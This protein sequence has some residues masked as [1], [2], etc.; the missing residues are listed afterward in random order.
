MNRLVGP[1]SMNEEQ[2]SFT[3]KTG[4]TTNVDYKVTQTKTNS[5]GSKEAKADILPAVGGVYVEAIVRCA[6]EATLCTIYEII[7]ASSSRRLDWAVPDCKLDA[8]CDCTCRMKKNAIYGK[9]AC[10]ME[11]CFSS[12]STVRT[13][14]GLEIPISDVKIGDKLQSASPDGKVV[15]AEVYGFGHREP[16]AQATVIRVE[17]NHGPMLELT[18]TH[19]LHSGSTCCDFNGLVEA[20]DLE[21]GAVIWVVDSDGTMAPSTVSSLKT[22]QATGMFNPLTR[23][24]SLIVNGIS[25]SNF[26]DVPKW[27]SPAAVHNWLGPPFRLFLLSTAIPA[28]TIMPMVRSCAR[29]LNP[30]LTFYM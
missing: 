23:S 13:D 18:S 2:V 4:L 19:M 28:D 3:S 7:E 30:V 6:K 5:D 8:N 1:F 25:A 24:S 9:C 16:A 27:T 12:S 20:K 14:A 10:S 26:A 22:L 29:M 21:I 15:Y 11:R 17:T